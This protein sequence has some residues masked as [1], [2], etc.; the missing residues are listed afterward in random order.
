MAEI[1]DRQNAG[2]PAYRPMAPAF[3]GP[4]FNAAR[5]LIFKGRAQPNGYTEWILHRRRREAKAGGAPTDLGARGAPTER[6]PEQT[7]KARPSV[8]PASHKP[9]GE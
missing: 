6:Q 1:V 7:T 5:D 8:R 4:A 9:G 2:D 3:D